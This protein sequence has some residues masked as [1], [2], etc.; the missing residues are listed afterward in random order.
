[1][2]ET[3]AL[4]EI[5]DGV[6]VQNLCISDLVAVQLMRL[7]QLASTDVH[8]A[9]TI[10]QKHPL[11][12]LA[13]RWSLD[14]QRSIRVHIWDSKF[15]WVQ[16]PNWQIHDHVF[17]F[18]SLVLTG[19]V[20]NKFYSIAA[21][22]RRRRTWQRYAV[23]Y[24]QNTSTMTRFG[25]LVGLRV[26][27]CQLHSQGSVY[28]VNAGVLHRSALKSDFAITVLVTN[29]ETTSAGA[30]LVVGVPLGHQVSYDRSV[31]VDPVLSN[32]LRSAAHRLA[33]G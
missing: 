27:S 13:C 25:G 15:D 24:D 2:S 5:A 30:P 20:L 17:S 19:T 28:E 32:I 7:G 22:A 6:A 16:S 18:R 31:A 3:A 23:R 8:V 14:A 4:A 1:M 11:G 26:E 9:S 33:V 12:F 29:T 10:V 21:S